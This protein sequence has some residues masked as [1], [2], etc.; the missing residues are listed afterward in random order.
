MSA[1]YIGAPC[2]LGHTVRYVADRKCVECKR[3]YARE[4]Y[5]ADPSL[6]IE[7]NR[8]WRSRNPEK[9]RAGKDRWRAANPEKARE[10]DKRRRETNRAHVRA[11]G[12]KWYAANTEK[13]QAWRRQ[14][15]GLPEP[16]R[17]APAS[18]ECCGALPGHVDVFST[19]TRTKIRKAAYNLA[20]DHDHVTGKFR[21]W[22]CSNCN[23]GLG[24][25]GDDIAGLER[26]IAYLRRAQ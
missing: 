5:A 17:P 14:Y 26:A 23:T 24:K 15:R 8:Q 21:G 22:L 10:Y 12:R 25:L 19:P 6:A 9:A 4:R 2:Q 11:M 1:T 18:C 13:V 16:T 20:L 3:A 7:K